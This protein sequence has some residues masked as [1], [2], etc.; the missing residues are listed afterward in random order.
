MN[1]PNWSAILETTDKG[2]ARPTLSNA[3][4]VIQHDPMFCAARIY[5]DEFLD[6]VLIANS[7]V[8]EWRADDTTRATVYMQD[9]CG[10][11]G[12]ND[13]W[14]KKAI[15]MVARDRPRHA[16]RDWLATL[17]W[18]GEPRID[19]AFVDYWNAIPNAQQPHDYLRAIS[20]NFFLGLIA[21]VMRPGCQL[22]EMV[23]FESPEQGVGK[24]SAL[25]ILGAPWYAVAHE[26]VTE[27]DFFQDLQGIWLVEIGEMQA[28]SKATRQRIKTVISTPTDRFRGSYDER[29]TNHPR[30]CVF[31]GSTNDDEWADDDTGLRRYWPFQCGLVERDHLTAARDQLFAEA[32]V[33]YHAGESW[34]PVPLSAKA[35]QAARQTY[36]EW[37]SVIMPWCELQIMQGADRVHVRDIMLGP[38]KFSVD[39]L[40]KGPQMRVATIL[41]LAR[42]QRLPSRIGE[43]SARAWFPPESQAK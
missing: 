40:D 35:V 13:I 9:A 12:L 33:R 10:I 29:S 22:D 14:V 18:D 20:K 3:V 26:R 27:K 16:V 37:T 42:W 1:A 36:D 11:T 19:E 28:F 21:R 4:R 31:A 43:N 39:K 23:V 8:R 41:R 34:W 38:L 6:R 5:Y 30:Q 2:V 7:P 15:A 32:L 24:T 25:R 17:A